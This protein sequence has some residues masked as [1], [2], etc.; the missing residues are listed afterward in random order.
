MDWPCRPSPRS[1]RTS[2]KSRCLTINVLVALC[3]IFSARAGGLFL[4][5]IPVQFVS[6]GSTI[7]LDLHQFYQPTP[8]SKSETAGAASLQTSYNRADL[9]LQIRV[10][11]FGHGLIDLPCK[12]RDGKETKEGVITLAVRSRT[13]TN[14]F[15]APAAGRP[16]WRSVGL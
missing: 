10:E 5:P 16:G 14:S 7:V 3:C 11:L 4:G 13:S 9:Q 6:A 8:G 2:L 15:I 12:I 1:P